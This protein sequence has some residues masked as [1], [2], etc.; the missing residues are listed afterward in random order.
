MTRIAAFVLAAFLA[1]APSALAQSLRPAITID[2]AVVRLGDVFADAGSRAA[3]PLVASPPPGTRITY[4][5]DWLAAAA[6]EHALDWQPSSPYDQITIERASRIVDSDAVRQQLLREIAAR[7]PVGD[8]ELQLDNPGLALVIPASTAPDIAID[9]LTIDRSGH[10]SAF[11]SAPAD[12]PAATRRRVTG[13]LVFH[14]TVPVLNHAV[15]PGAVIAASDLDSIKLPRERVGVDT[16]T[17]AQQMIGKS[18]RRPLE[19]G[20]PVRLG[21]LA[22][23]LLVHKG[24]LVTIQL[25]TSTLELT[26]QGTALEDGANGAQVRIS[27]TKSSR[28]IDATVTAPGTVAVSLPG[29]PAPGQTALR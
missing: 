13:R 6:R 3:D 12:D 19:A 25:R 8:A 11:V 18:P 20:I 21:D 23:P 10:I 7:E 27:N 9:G 2:A 17:D 29:S 4:G 15:G 5:A 24:Q 16:A 1:L 14:V 28:V 22:L 26:A